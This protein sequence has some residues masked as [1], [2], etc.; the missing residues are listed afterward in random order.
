MKIP[1]SHFSEYFKR[2]V[3]FLVKTELAVFLISI[4]EFLDLCTNM[5]DISYQL[6]FYGKTY[7]NKNLKLNNIILTISP[8]QY[9]FE[10]LSDLND[11]GFRKNYLAIIIYIVLFLWYFIYFMSI[12]NCNLDEMSGLE[13]LF[14]KISINF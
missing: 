7:D 12:T 10:Y 3:V 13:S 5:V 6:F 1:K 4:V 9:F 11:T 8:Y 2:S 14:Q